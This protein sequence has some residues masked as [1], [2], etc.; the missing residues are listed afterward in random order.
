[1]RSP[2]ARHSDRPGE[3]E[4]DRLP[5]THWQRRCNASGFGW[6]R[7]ASK[8][9]A[10]T[11]SWPRTKE[12]CVG[13]N[14]KRPG[15]HSINVY[16]TLRGRRSRYHRRA[17][18]LL[19]AHDH[20]RPRLGRDRLSQ[21]FFKHTMVQRRNARDRSGGSPAAAERASGAERYGELSVSDRRGA[22]AYS[23]GS[24]LR[25]ER[26]LRDELALAKTTH[27]QLLAE[28]TQRQQHV[29]VTKHVKNA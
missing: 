22:F 15:K 1:M 25:V 12:P 10:S 29:A 13:L 9:R 24:S 17:G 26:Q 5:P 3:A 8:H 2:T 23:A 4:G 19:P 18:L 16:G 27:E 28:Q 7:T 14:F 6:T 21:P 11:P 20:G